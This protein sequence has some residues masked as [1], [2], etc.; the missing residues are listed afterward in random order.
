MHI[1][2]CK[3]KNLNLEEINIYT[4]FNLTSGDIFVLDLKIEKMSKSFYFNFLSLQK[5]KNGILNKY[6]QDLKII[7]K[8]KNAK[9]YIIGK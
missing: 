7:L 1:S 9:E 2:D 6:I 3:I 4:K 8:Y 5:V